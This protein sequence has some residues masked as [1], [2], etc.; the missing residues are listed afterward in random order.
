MQSTFFF[1][2][3]TDLDK[4]YKYSW[5]QILIGMKFFFMNAK[6]KQEGEKRKK[7]R[8]TQSKHNER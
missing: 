6:V 5:F 1:L 7:N 8:D 2:H 4:I 3:Y